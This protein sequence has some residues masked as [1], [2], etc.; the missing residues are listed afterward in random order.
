MI[1]PY[2]SEVELEIYSD[3]PNPTI[4]QH[5]GY[6]FHNENGKIATLTAVAQLHANDLFK[7]F[8]TA[9]IAVI[10]ALINICIPKDINIIMQ[11]LSISIMI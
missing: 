1:K 11:I 2:S 4:N 7:I 6:I 3:V 9:Q 8:V 5:I 10:G